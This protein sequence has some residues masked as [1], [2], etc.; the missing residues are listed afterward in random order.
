VLQAFRIYFDGRI[1]PH[2]NRHDHLHR[3][4]DAPC[5]SRTPKAWMAEWAFVA[6]GPGIGFAR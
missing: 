3:R 5:Q 6:F 4:S 1:P 2:E